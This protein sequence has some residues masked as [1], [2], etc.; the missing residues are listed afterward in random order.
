MATDDNPYLA[1]DYLAERRGDGDAFRREYL[2]VFVGA[3]S[4]GELREIAERLRSRLERFR[5]VYS[6]RGYTLDRAD[7]DLVITV[8]EAVLRQADSAM[9]GDEP[10][11]HAA[12]GK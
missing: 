5:A 4:V 2:G 8:C 12:D 10:A 11:K 9:A 6:I 7:I 3:T 1:D